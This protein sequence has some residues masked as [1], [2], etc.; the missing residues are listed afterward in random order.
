MRTGGTLGETGEVPDAGQFVYGAVR[1]RRA[2]FLR[3]RQ[4]RSGS[5]P[6]PPPRKLNVQGS[7]CIEESTAVL[8]LQSWKGLGRRNGTLVKAGGDAGERPEARAARRRTG[9]TLV[10]IERLLTG[11]SLEPVFPGSVTVQ[12]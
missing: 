7:P 3:C 4:P 10:K 9:G 2:I 8:G 5:P 11:N 12:E 6:A 1:A